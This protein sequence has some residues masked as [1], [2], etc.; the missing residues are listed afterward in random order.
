MT[1]AIFAA[2]NILYLV[3]TR[4]IVRVFQAVLTNLKTIERYSRRVQLNQIF[5][6]YILI[7]CI[8]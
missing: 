7:I 8:P 4:L 2:V 6:C 3:F 5:F 1:I